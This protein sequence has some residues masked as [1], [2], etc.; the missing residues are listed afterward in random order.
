MWA[1]GPV[2]MTDAGHELRRLGVRRREGQTLLE[3]PASYAARRMRR[4]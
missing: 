2:D 1:L 4:V 3:R